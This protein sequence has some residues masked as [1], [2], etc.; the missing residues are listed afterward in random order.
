MVWNLIYLIID[1]IDSVINTN[2]AGTTYYYKVY[3]VDKAFNYS[4]ESVTSSAVQLSLAPNTTGYFVYT[5][6]DN[7]Q[8]NFNNELKFRTRLISYTGNSNWVE[9]TLDKM[10]ACAS[11]QHAPASGPECAYCKFVDERSKF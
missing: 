9:P 8:P 3:T 2:N 10:I 6:G 1:Y 4:D 11:Q 5:T 7:T